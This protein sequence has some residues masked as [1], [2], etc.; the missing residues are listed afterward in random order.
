VPR[1]VGRIRF[2]LRLA[3]AEATGRVAWI[4]H[5]HLAVARVQRVITSRLRCPYAV[6]L[7][8]IEAWETLGAADRAVLD[9]AALIVTNSIHTARRA[10][11]ANP[12]LSPITVCPLGFS[13]PDHAAV[14]P[15][16]RRA[17]TILTVARMAASERYK[18]HDQ[19][20]DALPDVLRHVPDARLVFVGT[21][22]DVDRLQHRAS[23]SG[24]GAH[25]T[26]TGFL[27]DDALQRA[28]AEA[29][30]FAMPS[31]GEGFGLA[32]LEA[33]A[34]GLPC[35]GSVHDAASEVI[36]DGVTGYLVDQQDTAEIAARL[37][38]LLTN[39]ERRVEMGRRGRERWAREFT[40]A[41]FRRRLVAA[42]DA[43]FRPYGA[44]ASQ[45]SSV[46]G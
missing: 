10:V 32:Y 33:M 29:S 41:H 6:F 25:V 45:P 18:G 19:L 30:V 42:L 2:G 46:H 7:H 20:I 4:F 21:G 24:V 5:S 12:G 3:S 26:F 36:D 16:S 17:P 43:P 39:P 22:D 13:S 8:G 38:G 1:T 15:E 34:S 44:R 9:D 31:R 35:V 37:S 23:A 27:P 28:Y 14:A 11:A 40:Y